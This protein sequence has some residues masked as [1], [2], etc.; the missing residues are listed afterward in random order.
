[1]IIYFRISPLHARNVAMALDQVTGYVSTQFHIHLDK[2]FHT[3]KQDGF[4]S[5]WSVKSKLTRQIGQM[6]KTKLLVK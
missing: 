1:M 2:G 5:L 4:G 6:G 3:V